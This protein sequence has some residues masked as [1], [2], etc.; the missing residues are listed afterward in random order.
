MAK[1]YSMDLRERVLAAVG[2]GGSRRQ[3]AARFGVAP[4]TAI[5]WMKRVERTGSAAPA[6][7]GQRRDAKIAGEH[8]VWLLER[9]KSGD[10]TLR[11]LVTELAARALKVDYKTVWK[12]VHAEK[13]SFKKKPSRQRT[14]S[15]GRGAAAPAVAALSGAD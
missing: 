1:A 11:G 10:F 2:G 8:R 7:P 5:G 6:T 13:L 3:A 12:F 14:R 4:S 15:R 9:C